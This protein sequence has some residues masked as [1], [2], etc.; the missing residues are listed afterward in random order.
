MSKGL[1]KSQV[2]MGIK[3]SLSLIN[4][5]ET[6]EYCGV[7]DRLFHSW[8][9]IDF[10]NASYQSLAHCYAIASTVFED[11]EIDTNTLIH[12]IR[13]LFLG[14]EKIMRKDG[15]L[16]EAFPNEKSYCVTALVGNDL[17]S[18]L[19][20]IDDIIDECERARY[21]CLIR[22]LGN[23]VIGADESHGVISNHL[24]AACAFLAKLYAM[25]GDDV[26]KS[27]YEALLGDLIASQDNDGWFPEYGGADPGYQSLCIDYLSQVY[28]ILPT[29]KL[30]ESLELALDFL[31]YACNPDGS[32]GG[33]YGARQTSFFAPGGVFSLARHFPSARRIC[34]FFLNGLSDE[35]FVTLLVLDDLN[36]VPFLN[37]YVRALKFSDKLVLDDQD[38]PLPL[39]LGINFSKNFC[40]AGILIDKND[41]VHTIVSYRSSFS[42]VQF[43][44]GN[45][46][47]RADLYV[48]REEKSLSF[49][50]PA[51]HTFQF[52]FDSGDFRLMCRRSRRTNRVMRPIDML[53]LRLM[54]LSVFKFKFFNGIIKKFLAY[55]L[56]KRDC[57]WGRSI[58]VCGNLRNNILIEFF[59]NKKKLNDVFPTVN[60]SNFHMASRGY[61]R[62]SGHIVKKNTY[63]ID[64]GR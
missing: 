45:V 53:V 17:I 11:D 36:L 29:V 33:Y 58:D 35:S 40:S 56:I 62:A 16:E 30:G 3:R 46:T 25:F 43:C 47:Y 6:H 34:N 42:I 57:T 28:E 22:S 9:L 37:S 27:A 54:S 2:I 26:Y 49:V 12:A 10:S 13:L 5:D 14:T 52:N 59:D 20:L 21:Q 64:Y 4:F 44:D 38:F 15:S 41:N 8:C 63:N 61:W 24:A 50:V 60:T 48:S 39:S 7:A 18:A 31:E 32:F 19:E 51:G 1:L 23:F 55:M